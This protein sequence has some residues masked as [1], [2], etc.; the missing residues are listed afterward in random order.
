VPGPFTLGWWGAPV[1]F[2]AV[3]WMTFMGIVFLFP[4][5][6]TTDTADM[7]YTIVVLGGVLILSLAWYYFPKYGGVHW[8]TGPVH[9]IEKTAANSR[10]GSLDTVE[11]TK[12]DASVSESHA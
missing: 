9:T 1:A 6:P 4:T 5:T 8:F 2:L 7:N 10:R 11:K 12:K 3:A